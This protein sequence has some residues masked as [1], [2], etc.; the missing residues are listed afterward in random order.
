M[1]WLGWVLWYINPRRLFNTKSC[2]Y[3]YILN[4]NDLLTHFVDNVFNRAKAP[5]FA[6]SLMVS[7]I[8]I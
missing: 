6:H 5:S 1:C 4:I 3:V 8:A 7:S 2:L